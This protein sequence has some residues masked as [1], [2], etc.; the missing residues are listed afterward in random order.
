M[1]R[2]IRYPQQCLGLIRD[3]SRKLHFKFSRPK[4]H[5]L[6]RTVTVGRQIRNDTRKTHRA[7]SLGNREQIL[8]PPIA[9]MQQNQERLDLTISR[10]CHPISHQLVSQELSSFCRTTPRVS[11][12]Q[13]SRNM[14]FEQINSCHH[15][16]VLFRSFKIALMIVLQRPAVRTR[17]RACQNPENDKNHQG[18]SR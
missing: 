6:C 16:T 11:F 5:G 9:P 13:Q 3:S 8:F 15:Q 2:Q 7:K 18:E 17:D 12:D 4:P 14:T 1:L 10:K